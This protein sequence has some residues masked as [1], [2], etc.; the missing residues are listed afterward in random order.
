M[1]S[2]VAATLGTPAAAG[3]GRIPTVGTGW[4]RPRAPRTPRGRTALR[5]G[6]NVGP[7]RGRPN[8]ALP[9]RWAGR[10]AG[11][12]IPW[13]AAAIRDP[14]WAREVMPSLRYTRAR[15]ASTVLGL[16]NAAAAICRFV[17]PPAA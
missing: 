13:G 4:R 10:L 2:G 8:R 15:F 3:I 5:R 1:S 17:M 7:R 6:A 12:W 9:Y 11:G 14:S 16:T